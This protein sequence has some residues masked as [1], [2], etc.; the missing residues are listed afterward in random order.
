MGVWSGGGTEGDVAGPGRQ[1]GGDGRRVPFNAF[2]GN[3]LPIQNIK[4]R[5]LFFF[6]QQMKVLSDIELEPVL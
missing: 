6:P 3:L 4:H 5:I 2:P 1:W